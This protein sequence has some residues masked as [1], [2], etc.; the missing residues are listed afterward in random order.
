[1]LVNKAPGDG[2]LVIDPCSFRLLPSCFNDLIARP[3]P[4]LLQLDEL[5]LPTMSPFLTPAMRQMSK[6]TSKMLNELD[7]M[8]SLKIASS[9]LLRAGPAFLGLD[10]DLMRELGIND[11]GELLEDN[12]TSFGSW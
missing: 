6:M 3:V 7:A 2:S 8:N 4:I 11:E 9:S 12:M 10:R 5:R 1:M